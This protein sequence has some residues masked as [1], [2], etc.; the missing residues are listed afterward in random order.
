MLPCVVNFCTTGQENMKKAKRKN[1]KPKRTKKKG[2]RQL[3]IPKEH[4]WIFIYSTGIHTSSHGLSSRRV[5][6]LGIKISG[7]VKDKMS[8]CLTKHQNMKTYLFLNYAPRHENVLGEW[9]Y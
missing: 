1:K 5:K 8:L 2:N 6:A 9:R 7:K 3:K 4:M